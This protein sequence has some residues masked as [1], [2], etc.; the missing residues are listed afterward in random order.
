M[1]TRP[2]D[3]DFRYSMSEGTSVSARGIS[4][5]PTC[6]AADALVHRRGVG[7]IGTLA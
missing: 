4:D 6:L 1:A 2:R 3:I 5:R 7:R